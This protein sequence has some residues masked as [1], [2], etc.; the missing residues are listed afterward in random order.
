MISGIISGCCRGCNNL[1][2]VSVWF[3]ICWSVV[4][5]VSVVDAVH[6]HPDGGEELKR[7]HRSLK[8]DDYQMN[9]INSAFCKNITKEECESMEQEMEHHARLLQQTVHTIGTVRVLVL[10]VRFAD[11]T[12]RQLPPKEQYEELFIGAGIS[13]VIPTGS[14]KDYLWRNS[15]GKMAIEVEVAD[16][17]TTDNT[18]D[19]YSFNVSGISHDT[20]RA[21]YP[22]LDALD[23]QNFDFSPFDQNN[24]GL[25]D[26]IVMLHSGFAAEVGGRDCYNNRH[27]EQRIWA[28][29]LP[30]QADN[31]VSTRTGIRANGYCIS[32]AIRGH[33][34]ARPA[35]IGVTTHEMLHVFGLPDLNDS[36]GGW[37]GKGVGEYD[38]MSSA[39]ARNG[40]QILPAHLSPWSK[41]KLGWLNPIEI[42]MD[43]EYN[44]EAS[45][46]APDVFIVRAGFP[47]PDLEY[48]VIENRQPIG[49][50]SLLWEGGLLIWHMDNSQYYLKNRG[51][52]GQEGWPRNGKHYQIAL[53]QADRLYDL[54]T[55]R[56]SGDN[57]DFWRSGMGPLGPGLVE[58]EATTAGTYPNTN[59]YIWGSITQTGLTFSDFSQ[60]GTVMS[61]RV[62]GIS[63]ALSPAPITRLPTPVPTPFPT[64]LPTPDPTPI[65]TPDPT[66]DPTP[67]P[68]SP[69]PSVWPT[70]TPSSTPTFAPS[71]VASISPST[72]PRPSRSPTRQPSV[73]PSYLPT[74]TPTTQLPTE[75]ATPSSDPTYFPST[76][77][78]AAP[79]P[80]FPVSSFVIPYRSATT[81]GGTSS[82]Y[83]LAE[84]VVLS[85][86]GVVITAIL[87]TL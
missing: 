53:A 55:G 27:H 3:S 12:D 25:I 45:E 22:A 60:S 57:G 73:P 32:T 65:P 51:Y 54:E 85:M 4:I 69:P 17:V 13:D 61:F 37:I 52:P 29:A 7:Y 66:P 14:I 48:F 80:K 77:P 68:T 82:S 9:Y 33:C 62:A 86:V 43:G 24:D 18:E 11:H 58:N 76:S 50:D 81:S 75:T 79:L 5:L 26:L 63:P 46:L 74:F 78:S 6:P 19:Y 64:P 31:W 1:F 15:Y 10:L 83:V 42:V 23:K 87:L 39:H 67:L 49:Y 30:A 34:F 40:A 36:S 38:I 16:W 2:V 41:M 56:N 35:R 8:R 84:K 59:S 20:R 47:R 44:I 71:T 21:Y 70:T 72:S 28:H